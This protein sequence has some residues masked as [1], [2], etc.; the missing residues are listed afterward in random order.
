[1]TLAIFFGA[2]TSAICGVGTVL[3]FGGLYGSPEH[4]LLVASAGGRP[5]PG[6]SG[7]SL[8]MTQTCEDSGPRPP[9]RALTLTK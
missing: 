6:S 8:S 9:L 7:F 5:P 2:D 1:M 3:L 4:G